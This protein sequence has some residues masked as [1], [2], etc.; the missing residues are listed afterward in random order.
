MT[1]SPAP[2]RAKMTPVHR[3]RSAHANGGA[4]GV[5]RRFSLAARHRFFGQAP[6][7]WGRKA[8]KANAPLPTYRR[9]RTKPPTSTSPAP[10]RAKMSKDNRGSSAHANGGATGVKK[11]LSL[12]ARHRFFGQAPKKW[13]RK[14]G[15]G[16]DHRPIKRRTRIS[17]N[18]RGNPRR[19]FPLGPP[20]ALL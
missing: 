11:R 13:G 4:A 5:K 8:G 3:G 20:P 14:A 6:K 7:K 10:S 1:T 18:K 2:S 16:K 19:G 9:T 15:Q 17:V 12:A